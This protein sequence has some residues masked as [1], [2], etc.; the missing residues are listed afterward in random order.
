MNY[1]TRDLVRRLSS[2]DDSVVNAAHRE[3]EEANERYERH[4]RTIEPELPP[5][6]R[7]F[8]DLLLHDAVVSN[9]AREGD[10]LIMVLQKDIPPR[11]TVIL[12]YS[13][14]EDPVIDPEAL[15]AEDRLKVMDFQYDEFDL[16]RA[17][18]NKVYAQ[19][20]VFGNGWEMTLR[21][22]DV[23]VTLAQALYPF[24]GTMLVPT[25][26]SVLAQSA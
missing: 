14:I 26:T 11:D 22:T 6:V 7:E 4:L 23:R 21:F 20:I 8:N 15:P 1:F 12:T 19:G 16:V 25:A 18:E 2:D 5:H 3:W 17:G 24:P 13:L 10:K 9:I